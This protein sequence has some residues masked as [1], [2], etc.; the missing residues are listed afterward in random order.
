MRM[1]VWRWIS[2][3]M[4]W[5]LAELVMISSGITVRQHPIDPRKMTAQKE[6]YRGWKK[7][8]Q[9]YFRS[10]GCMNYDGLIPWN[11]TV[12]CATF[13]TSFFSD[14]KTTN[15]LRFGEQLCWPIM[16]FRSMIEYHPISAKDQA[17]LN[18]FS[19]NVLLSA[20]CPQ[21]PPC[22]TVFQPFHS[23]GA[24][25]LCSLQSVSLWSSVCT[26]TDRDLV[27]WL[28]SHLKRARPDTTLPTPPRNLRWLCVVRGRGEGGKS[29]R[30]HPRSR[31]WESWKFW[32]L[33]EIHAWRLN[34][35]ESKEMNS[36]S[37]AQIVLLSWQEKVMKSE[38]PSTFR[39]HPMKEKSSTMIFMEKRT[40]QI[41]HNNCQRMTF[42]SWRWPLSGKLFYRHHVQ[43]RVKLY[44]PQEGTFPIPLKNIDVVH[45]T[46]TILHVLLE[47][48]KDHY[49]NIDGDPMLPRP[50]TGFT[51]F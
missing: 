44:V 32:L 23:T 14:W 50:W 46:H 39:V 33:S 3:T 42:W 1:P 38:H 17:R 19:K 31:R 16:P 45:Q 24:L 49:R 20:P 41:Q 2:Q 12:I 18:P 5:N 13:K 48:R 6:R 37:R 4:H 40:D 8:S 47:S 29:E 51:Q 15:E 36:Y 43:P 27:V 11:V 34:A 7:V 10:P 21:S 28:K 25:S 30:R 22:T 26:W 35:K 9:R